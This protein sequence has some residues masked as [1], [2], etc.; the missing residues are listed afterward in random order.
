MAAGDAAPAP[1]RAPP[2][3]TLPRTDLKYRLTLRIIALSALCFVAISTWLLVSAER[4]ARARLDTI[5][6]ITAQDLALQRSKRDWVTSAGSDFPDLQDIAAPLMVPGLCL[7]YRT[8]GGDVLQ[9]VCGGTG[10]AAPDDPPAL[11]AALYRRLFDP[12]RAAVAPVLFRG[13]AI[14]A[15]LAWVDPAMLTAQA[16]GE[17]S[18]LLAVMGV[19]LLLLCGLVYAALAR[20]LRP[21]RLIRAGLE[22]IAADDLSARL[23]PFDL[24]ELSAIR[25]VFNHLAERLERT[26]A[27]RNELTRRLI[28]LQDDERR[29]L[30]RELHDEFGQCLAAIRALAAS[31]GQTAAEHCPALLPECAS[32]ERTAA[33]MAETLRGAL[34]R[35]RPPDVEE[36]GL[37]QSLEGLIAGWNSRSRGHP[38]FAIERRGRVEDVPASVA[39]GLYRIA[40]EALTNAAKHAEATQVVLRLVCRA[41]A[42]IELT[43]AD[44]GRTAAADRAARG[45]MGLLGMRERAAGLGGS[46]SFEGSPSGAVLRVLIRLSPEAGAER[47]AAF[48]A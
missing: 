27:E 11:F 16:W 35:L 41:P 6:A 46:L 25:S 33:H 34:F 26:L 5:A 17:T 14:G 20:A 21:T 47:A 3:W 40:Q 12:G 30:A 43:V 23:P 15:A 10:G 22:R 48:P 31:A 42:E 13:A 8:A 28:A 2:M 9:R 38:G 19:T 45:G 37:A 24:A 7:A 4:A 44:D 36:L 39:A 32:I 1:P 29:H 18:R